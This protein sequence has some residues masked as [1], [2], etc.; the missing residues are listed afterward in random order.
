MLCFRWIQHHTTKAYVELN[1][2]VDQRNLYFGTTMKFVLVFNASYFFASS[3]HG[4]TALVGLGLNIV[5]VS[6]SRR[7]T[8]LC[9]IPLDKWTGLVRDLYLKIHDTQKRQNS[10]L[11]VGFETAVPKSERPQPHALDR[12]WPLGSALVGLG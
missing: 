9:R 2:H 4:S 12:V 11:P 3:S 7:H 1:R 10:M 5:E 6:I 8:T